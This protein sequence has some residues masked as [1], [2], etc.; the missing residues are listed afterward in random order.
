MNSISL[1]VYFTFF[2]IHSS[3]DGHCRHF[4]FL[5]V[6]KSAAMNMGVQMSLQQT[7]CI[8]FGY[9][10]SSEI[11]GSYGGSIFNF[12]G[13][14][15]TVFHNDCTDL[16]FHQQCLRALYLFSNTCFIFLFSSCLFDSGHPKWGEVRFHV[17]YDLCFPDD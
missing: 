1:Y 6:V 4:H 11:A 16:H 5:S 17:V 7:D 8:S 13:A 2:P 15:H 9:R 3:F 14:F 10:L 12:Y